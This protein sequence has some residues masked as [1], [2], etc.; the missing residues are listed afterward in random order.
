MSL[1]TEAKPLSLAIQTLAIQNQKTAKSK[2]LEYVKK[3]RYKKL[4]LAYF[5]TKNMPRQANRK[6]ASKEILPSTNE[7][8]NTFAENFNRWK[9]KA[10]KKQPLLKMT[11]DLTSRRMDSGEADSTEAFFTSHAKSSP[12]TYL[13]PTHQA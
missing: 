3:P 8:E 6:V 12:K 7:A 13:R 10:F 11:L 1:N 5:E 4:I 9:A 2:K